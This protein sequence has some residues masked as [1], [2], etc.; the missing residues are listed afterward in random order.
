MEKLA[1][2]PNLGYI[3]KKTGQHPNF[4]ESNTR[5]IKDCLN[6]LE[7]NI[8]EGERYIFG[9]RK[10]D[11]FK[12]H[13]VIAFKSP[14]KQIYFYDAQSGK[15]YDKDLLKGIEFANRRFNG[16]INKSPQLL[17]IDDKELNTK[18]LDKVSKKY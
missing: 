3:D 10:S 13:V 2:Y 15:Y 9:F 17:R 5:N 4:V 11:D 1:A 14:D 18:M 6:Y 12:K 7:R 16:Y 8:N